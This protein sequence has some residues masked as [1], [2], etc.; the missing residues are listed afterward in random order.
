MSEVTHHPSALRNRDPI[1]AELQAVLP[2]DV[3]GLAL[4]VA[5]GT[6][7]HVEIFA[8]AFPLV[9]FQP[10]EFDSSLGAE[11]GKIGTFEGS[12]LAIIDG[13][14]SKLDNVNRA[15]HLDVSAPFEQWPSFVQ[16]NEG[17]FSLIYVSNITHITPFECT[18]GLVAGSGRALLQ[19][20]HLMVYGP[21]KVDGEFT[22]ESNAA[23]DTSLR[24]RNSS[25]GY[26]DVADVAAEAA[27]HGLELVERKEMPANNLM[28]RFS[29][30]GAT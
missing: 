10:T 27:K 11:V 4:E 26:R 7:A 29:K 20:G 25:W 24:E 18:Q 6:G 17:K 15:A 13:F 3:E 21:F 9:R 19:G 16:E 1:L 23:F 28:L 8:P 2:A 14:T 5:S 22:T 30:S 12:Q